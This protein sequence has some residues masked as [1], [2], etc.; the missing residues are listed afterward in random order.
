MKVIGAGV[1]RT[2]TTSTK[3]ALEELGF[4]PC[5]TFFTLFSLPEHI[6]QW[7]AAYAGEPIDWSRFLGD[8]E[9][10][11]DW[12]A[13]DFYEQHMALYP[14]APVV[15]T[16]REPESWYRSMTNTIWEV[17]QA[18][19]EAGQGPDVNPMSR[20]TE[21]MIWQRFFGGRFLDKA[22]AIRCFEQHIEQVKARVPSERLLV[23]DVKQGWEPLCR[24]LGVEAPDKPFPHLLDTEAFRERVRAMRAQSA[25]PPA[26]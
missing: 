22:H 23:F 17:N 16:V 5:Y 26:E 6:E 8:F 12:P 14:E 19:R 21:V 18:Q 24:F 11:V 9:S 10:T 15:L 20:L 1:G 2:G 25:G 7:L 4:G 13:C 3:A